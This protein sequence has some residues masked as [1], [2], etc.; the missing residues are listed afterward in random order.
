MTVY[1]WQVYKL[2]AYGIY[3]LHA[4]TNNSSI[5]GRQ[6]PLGGAIVGSRAADDFVALDNF[7]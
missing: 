5:T 7:I 1:C 3:H 6:S 2:D 4:N